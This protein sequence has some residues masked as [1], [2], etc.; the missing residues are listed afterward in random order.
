M[1]IIPSGLDHVPIETI[2][3]CTFIVPVHHRAENITFYVR[4]S[5]QYRMFTGLSPRALGQFEPYLGLEFTAGE[6]RVF[7]EP[8]SPSLGHRARSEI[9]FR[10]LP[11]RE[12][13]ASSEL[14]GSSYAQ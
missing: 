11:Q 10:Q 7:F 3:D 6:F 9:R 12:Q 8:P 14:I 1:S 13:R 4:V 2:V 5:L